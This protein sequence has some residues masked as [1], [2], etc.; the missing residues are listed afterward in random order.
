MKVLVVYDSRYGNTEQVARAIAGALGETAV[1]VGQADAAMVEDHELLIVG[2]PT[3]GGRPTPAVKQFIDSISEGALSRTAVAA[4]DTRVPAKGF[5]K[6]LF[7][8]IGY[9]AG[10]IAAPLRAKGGTLVAPP[11]GFLVK[12]TE[13][14]LQDGELERAGAW[15]RTLIG[16]ETH[17]RA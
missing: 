3:Q 13:G 6:V 17:T 4:F 8:V 15:A 14:P 9:A 5:L 10:K 1:R 16:K 2:S 11:E 7:G 12:G